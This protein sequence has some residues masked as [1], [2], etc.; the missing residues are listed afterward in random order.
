MASPSRRLADIV[1][2][3]HGRPDYLHKLLSALIP[4]IPPAAP[5]SVIAVN[6]GTHSP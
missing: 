2:P 6:D 5:V 4:Q 1:V 3:T